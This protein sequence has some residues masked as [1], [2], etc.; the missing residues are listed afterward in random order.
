M[1]TIEPNQNISLQLGEE[2]CFDNRSGYITNYVDM[3]SVM[4]RDKV[5]GKLERVLIDNIL[6]PQS[7]SNKLPDN[8]LSLIPDESWQLAQDRLNIIEPLLV[9][10]KRTRQDV[11]QRADKFAKHPNTLYQ[12]IRA[13]EDFGNLRSLM[14]KSRKDSGSKRLNTEIEEIINSCIHEH[15]LTR[16]RK[17]IAYVHRK[18]VSTCHERQ[19]DPPH[20]NT[21]RNRIN[22]ISE[23]HKVKKRH[24]GIISSNKFAPVQGKTPGAETPFA[25]YQMDHTPM[26]VIV[27]DED[28]RHA[29]G[30]PTLTM[31][32]DVFSRMVAGF[33]I[34]FEP[35]SALAAGMCMAH[36]LL[37][38]QNGLENLI[39]QTIGPYGETLQHY[40]WIMLVSFE[41]TCLS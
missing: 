35:P 37:P 40:T 17:S 41:V 22:S 34:S 10:D 30:R 26:D 14:N 3:E 15:Y 11:Q 12:W 9:M 20:Q 32:I 36:A 16:E 8:D 1:D 23:R 6:A 29:V 5:S 27:V 31:I 25:M 21:I 7:S 28:D 18:I 19:I 39:H 38:K 24:G 4:V 2:V 33:Y 13:Y